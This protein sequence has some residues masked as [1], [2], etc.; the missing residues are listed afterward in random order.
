MWYSVI[1]LVLYASVCMTQTTTPPPPCD[2]CT[3]L[4]LTSYEKGMF[5]MSIILTLVGGLVIGFAIGMYTFKNNMVY[6][7]PPVKTTEYQNLL[8]QSRKLIIADIDRT[9]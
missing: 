1:L 6:P 2:E 4:R 8:P 7:T 5:A 9:I 3:I